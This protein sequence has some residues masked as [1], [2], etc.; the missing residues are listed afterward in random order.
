MFVKFVNEINATLS[1]SKKRKIQYSIQNVLAIDKLEPLSRGGNVSSITPRL[2]D[3]RDF[4]FE[5]K[6]R[7]DF[8]YTRILEE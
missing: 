4:D 1:C 2:S 8:D 7:L 3:I 5:L 6:R